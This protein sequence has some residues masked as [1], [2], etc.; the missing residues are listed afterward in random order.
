MDYYLLPVEKNEIDRIED[1][2]KKIDYDVD[3]RAFI[4]SAEDIDKILITMTKEN[5]HRII[6]DFLPEPVADKFAK[7]F[8]VKMN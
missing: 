7:L 3:D 1:S 6:I 4:W 8:G 5:A 2:L